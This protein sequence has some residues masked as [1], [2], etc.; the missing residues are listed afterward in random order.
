VA[1]VRGAGAAGGHVLAGVDDP[2]VDIALLETA[3]AEAD[4]HAGR[5][6]V[7]HAQGGPARLLGERRAPDV[8]AARLATVV[9][10]LARRHP[11]VGVE[12]RTPHRGAGRALLDAARSARLV[13][14]GFR[15]RGTTA[16]VLLGSHSHA[17]L[18]HSP[19]PVLV[20]ASGAR[21]PVSGV[22]APAGHGF[23]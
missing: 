20:V 11:G 4:R 18:R 9:S 2:E 3:F 8:A 19:A 13:V 17:L 6:V 16:R 15:G 5:V 23:G 10:T 7:V 21:R 22:A 14:V 1:V 12:M